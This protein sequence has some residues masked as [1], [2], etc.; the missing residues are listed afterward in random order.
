MSKKIKDYINQRK[1]LLDQSLDAMPNI[2]II[3]DYNLNVLY[4]N[5]KFNNKFTDK[6]ETFYQVL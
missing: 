1:E 4:T 5:N 2:W 3:T 6:V